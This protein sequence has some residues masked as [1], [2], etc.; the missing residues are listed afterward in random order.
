MKPAAG[1][2]PQRLHALDGVRGIAAIAVVL[3]HYSEFNGTPWFVHG[4]I[5]VD[6]FVCLSGFV[7]AHT[8]R[9]G[10]EQGLPFLVFARRRLNRLYPLYLLGLVCGAFVFL[11]S[12]LR[13]AAL[14]TADTA[15][16]LICGLLVLPSPNSATVPA[17]VGP[18]VGPLFPF[19]APAWSMFFELAVNAVFFVVIARRVRRLEV[20]VAL[21]VSV[22]LAAALAGAGLNSGWT[23]AYGWAGLPRTLSAFFL[24]VLLHGWHRGGRR[25]SMAVAALSVLVMLAVFAA[26]ASKP[27]SV[28]GVLCTGPL[29][30]WTCA[31][32]RPGPRMARWCELLGQAS[33]PLYIIHM[34]LLNGVALLLFGQGPAQA[35]PGM[36][37]VAV[38]V[39]AFALAC[40]LAFLDDR[41]RRRLRAG[42]PS[43]QR[44]VS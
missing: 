36:F 20:L 42:K 32:A 11:A 40:A 10:V 34:P 15:A 19:N 6:V 44:L 1:A 25:V 33:Y 30:V 28:L 7:I 8:Y 9:A 43:P 2:A 41:L 13:R 38:T 29:V 39:L 4:W 24:G 37:T 23:S 18:L 26:P 16:A 31:A 12:D 14:S 35:R 21:S 22:Y 17:G 3:F 5:A 27:V